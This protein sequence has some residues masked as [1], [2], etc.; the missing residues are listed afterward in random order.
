MEGDRMP[1]GEDF[2]GKN[3]WETT[4]GMI[5]KDGIPL[6]EVF[7]RMDKNRCIQCNS[8]LINV[9]D[10]VTKKISVYSWQC[11]NEKCSA[12]KVILNKG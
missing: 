10:S 1:Q 2:K 9:V 3:Y 12:R 7:K 5:G 8:K 11:P 6:E 4:K